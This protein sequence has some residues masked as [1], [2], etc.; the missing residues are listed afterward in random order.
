MKT[1]EHWKAVWP[2]YR[3]F[4]HWVL[5]T[6]PEI[7]LRI[8]S[9]Y[10]FLIVTWDQSMTHMT[11]KQRDFNVETT[12]FIKWHRT[13]FIA[14]SHYSKRY[15]TCLRNDGYKTCQQFYS[16]NEVT[17]LKID[18]QNYFPRKYQVTNSTIM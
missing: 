1:K 16:V 18:A 14:S 12:Y 10:W 2:Q 15:R 17:L 4:Q 11:Y 9:P 8:S 13:R 5:T 3:T 7:K 6:A